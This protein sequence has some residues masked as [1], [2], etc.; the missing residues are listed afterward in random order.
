[1]QHGSYLM[2]NPKWTNL[3]FTSKIWS[4]IYTSLKMVENEDWWKIHEEEEMMN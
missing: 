4:S 3:S 1:M 2:W